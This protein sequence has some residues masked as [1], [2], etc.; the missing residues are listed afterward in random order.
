MVAIWILVVLCIAG[1]LFMGRFFMAMQAEL[2]S[3]KRSGVEPVHIHEISNQNPS[4]FGEPAGGAVSS[5]THRKVVPIRRNSKTAIWLMGVMLVAGTSR[6]QTSSG[7]SQNAPQT[8]Q[9]GEPWQYGV[10]VDA[11]YLKDF[12]DPA[13]GRFRS[14]GTTYKVDEPIVDMTAAYLR[15]APAEASR[16]GLE[17]TVQAGQDTRV[18]GFSPTAPNLPGS[19]GLRHFGPTDVSYLAPIGK[20]LTIQGGIFSSLIGYDGLYAKDNFNYSRPWGADFTP[21]L[22]LGINASYPVTSKLTATGFVVNGYWH[23][24]NANGVPSFG[25]Q[26]AYKATG[27]VNLK[28]TVMY[29]PHQSDTALEFWRFLSDT[30]AEYKAD[31]FTT[32]LEYH[33]GT[34]KVA[35]PG[36][37]QPVWMAA[38]LPFHL[39]LNKHWSVTER[40]EVYWD[41]TGRITGFAQTVKANTATL[42]YR[43]PYQKAAAIF[44]IE[45]RVD[46]S[47]G[48]GGGFFTSRTASPGVVGLAPTQHLLA[49]ALILTFDSSFRR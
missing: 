39:V 21:Y 6:G 46:D 15:K 31:R 47:R 14:R 10:S 22:M 40:P 45:H 3:A 36:N 2:R 11:A 7:G 18:F 24:G 19:T 34:E 12:N 49:F 33:V 28:Q 27:H 38:Q 8:N 16:W 42:E 29:G 4:P 20:G 17:L 30:I 35:A 1:G 44:R 5:A 26:L 25:G 43:I 41:S 13:N 48:P 23:L 32:A 37:P 9:V